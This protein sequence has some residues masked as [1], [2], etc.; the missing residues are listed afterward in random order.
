MLTLL[1]PILT[2]KLLIYLDMGDNGVTHKSFAAMYIDGPLENDNFVIYQFKW[3][4]NFFI[5]TIIGVIHHFFCK[6]DRRKSII[7][8][9]TDKNKRV[10]ILGQLVILDC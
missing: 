4:R 3:Y 6:I 2:D 8:I 9:V 1:T 7:V 5:I 10:R